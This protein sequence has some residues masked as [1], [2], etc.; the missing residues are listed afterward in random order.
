MFTSVRDIQLTGYI[1]VRP[2]AAILF[3]DHTSCV[4]LCTN[5]IATHAIDTDSGQGGT[6][7]LPATGSGPFDIE[8]YRV[9]ED[10]SIPK[11]ALE[12]YKLSGDAVG[13][14]IMNHT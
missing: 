1:V 6:A 9:I 11:Q 14:I 4:I 10:E 2:R 12:P 7:A 13:R 8:L 3:D 5:G